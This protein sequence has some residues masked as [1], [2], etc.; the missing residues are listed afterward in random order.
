MNTEIPTPPE[1]VLAKIKVQAK[2]EALKW[3]HN[4]MHTGLTRDEQ[5]TAQKLYADQLNGYVAARERSLIEAW[6]KE[7][8]GR[9][10]ISE[11]EQAI[12]ALRLGLR[13]A[14]AIRMR[15]TNSEVLG[16]IHTYESACDSFFNAVNPEQDR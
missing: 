15:S 9:L 8:Q 1:D 5:I 7:Q 2:A 14:Q 12:E 4:E 10:P 13:V 6:Q 3:L 16:A 11:V